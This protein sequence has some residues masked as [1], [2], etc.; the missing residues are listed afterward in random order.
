MFD[1]YE[2]LDK[3]NTTEYLND[4]WNKKYGLGLFFSALRERG[5][6]LFIP[7][8][9]YKNDI[10][11]KF[12]IHHALHDGFSALKCLNTELD[13]DLQINELKIRK[14]K[15]WT[16]ALFQALTSN[17]TISHQFKEQ[18]INIGGTDF[19]EIYFEFPIVS[20]ETALYT[21]VITRVCM[22]HLSVN[23]KSRW[24]IPVRTGEGMGLNASYLG[25]E[26][27][28]RDSVS[29][30]QE[31]IKEK[32]IKGEHWG[33]Y[34]ISKLGLFMGRRI[35][36]KGTRN[37]LAKRK[38][39]WLGSVSNLGHLGSSEMVDR[40]VIC[41]PIRWHRPIGASLYQFN[42]KQCV[43]LCIH[44]SL[45]SADLNAIEADITHQINEMLNAK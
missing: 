9:I 23:S 27:A 7:I 11:K 36:T 12:K 2:V 19:S 34:L 18:D 32:L 33:N 37:S 14:P 25:I 8:R 30:T 21:N 4:P 3:V 40:L 29:N 42:G 10:E 44:H 43:A 5:E 28:E 22:K 24:M 35:I 15:S 45:V 31:K 26:I 41:P 1:E 16:G 39:R 38:S 20:N 13:L 17:P 6:E